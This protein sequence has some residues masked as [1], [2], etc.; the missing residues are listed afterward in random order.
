MGLSALQINR[1][2]YDKFN[3]RSEIHSVLTLDYKWIINR[4]FNLEPAIFWITDTKYMSLTTLLRANYNNKFWGIAGYRI[5]DGIV[6]A[7]G[8]IIRKRVGFGYNLDIITSKLS[9]A[10]SFSHGIFLNYQIQRAPSYPLKV[11]G[12][13]DF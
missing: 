1:P 12:T 11:I 9:N 7:A 3:F 5:D 8:V 13:P 2:N 4:K 6:L 10:T